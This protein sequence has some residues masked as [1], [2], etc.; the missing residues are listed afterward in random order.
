VE[1]FVFAASIGISGSGSL[2]YVGALMGGWL[3]L[4]LA[5]NWQREKSDFA[6][7]RGI[8]ALV[9]GLTSMFFAFVGGLLAA[10]A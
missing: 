8:L 6:R 5:T 4:K 1:R 2:A 3:A 9:N 7:A 10:G